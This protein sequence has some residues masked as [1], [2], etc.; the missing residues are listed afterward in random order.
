MSLATVVT[1]T[2][3]VV[4]IAWLGLVLGGTW[5]QLR[6]EVEAEGERRQGQGR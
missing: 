3:L 6:D 1:L 5:N 2:F 4:L